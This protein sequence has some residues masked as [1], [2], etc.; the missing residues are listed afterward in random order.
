[1]CL[2]CNDTVISSRWFISMSRSDFFISPLTPPPRFLENNR[3][4]GTMVLASCWCVVMFMF[5][6]CLTECFVGGILLNSSM[7]LENWLLLSKYCL[8]LSREFFR[9]RINN[10]QSLLLEAHCC[11]KLCVFCICCHMFDSTWGRR[12]EG[13][14]KYLATTSVIIYQGIKL[15]C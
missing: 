7:D 14:K 1:M 9:D 15:Q 3:A 5:F 4:V 11:F 2:K 6:S 10:L 13:L 8:I 12:N